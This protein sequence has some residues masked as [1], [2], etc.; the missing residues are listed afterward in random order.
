MITEI[1]FICTFLYCEG[2]V[3]TSLP[4]AYE[5][6]G[7][8]IFSVYLSVHWGWGYPLVLGTFLGGSSWSLVLGPFL[9]VT[10]PPP[11]RTIAQGSGKGGPPRQGRGYPLPPSRQAMPR[12]VHFLQSRRR[13]FLCLY[14]FTTAVFSNISE[15]VGCL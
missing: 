7:K 5:V 2:K 4:S 8:V 15:E 14:A 3:K 6:R 9:G 1:T 13:T 10:P 11:V 12:A